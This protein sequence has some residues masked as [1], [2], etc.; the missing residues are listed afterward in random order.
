MSKKIVKLTE[1]TLKEIINE[2][3]KEILFLYEEIEEKRELI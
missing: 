2:S 1:S 3:V